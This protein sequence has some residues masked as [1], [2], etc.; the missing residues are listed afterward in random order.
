MWLSMP[1]PPNFRAPERGQSPLLTLHPDEVRD[2]RKNLENAEATRDKLSSEKDTLQIRC[3]EMETRSKKDRYQSDESHKQNLDILSN[4]ERMEKQVEAL[5]KQ[6]RETNAELAKLQHQVKDQEQRNKMVEAQLNAE[7]VKN[8]NLAPREEFEAAKEEIRAAKAKCLE[9][10]E[11][12]AA[13]EKDYQNIVEAYKNVSGHDTG[14][15][16]ARPLTPRPF[17]SHCR[18]VLDPDALRT[19]QQSELLQDLV[20]RV[21]STARQVLAAYGLH[22]AAQKSLVFAKFAKHPTTVPLVSEASLSVGDR[23]KT[24]QQGPDE[25]GKDEQGLRRRNSFTQDPRVERP[26]ATVSL[27]LQNQFSGPTVPRRL[28]ESLPAAL[29]KRLSPDEYQALKERVDK[30]LLP[31]AEAA[32]GMRPLGYLLCGVQLLNVLIL[33]ILVCLDVFLLDEVSLYVAE[34]I[35]AVVVTS[36]VVLGILWFYRRLSRVVYE[37]E[38]AL[39]VALA[40]E[41]AKMPLTL[42]LSVQPRAWH[43]PIFDI[44]VVFGEKVAASVPAPLQDLMLE[45]C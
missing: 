19:M 8:A 1:L 16:E 32:R 24:P 41:C 26:M 4:L 40:E 25:G 45:K 44:S 39:R 29:D 37:A 43:L 42:Q 17:W 15:V 10:E 18:G 21:L 27:Q 2:L 33:G 38:T 28:H 7:R 35:L 11:R 22:S 31:I 3:S 30:E 23:Q 34:G 5:R 9:W 36:I 20:V 14:G 6:D 12:Y 13:K